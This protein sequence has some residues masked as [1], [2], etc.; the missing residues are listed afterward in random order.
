[1]R[2]KNRRTQELLC[3]LLLALSVCFNSYI[4]LP[5]ISSFRAAT[6]IVRGGYVVVD[7][8]GESHHK[9]FQNVI[10]LLFRHCFHVRHHTVVL[11]P[12]FNELPFSLCEG[13][14]S[15]LL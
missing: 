1:M 5:F 6:N 10:E 15:G 11:T 4:L 7:E 8:D 2:T 9:I 12:V 3:L 14:N 13:F